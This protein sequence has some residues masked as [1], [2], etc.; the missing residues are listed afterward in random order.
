M[1]VKTAQRHSDTDQPVFFSTLAGEK[2]VEHGGQGTLLVFRITELLD[3]ERGDYSWHGP[4]VGDVLVVDSDENPELNGKVLRGMEVRFAPTWT[5]RGQAKPGDDV[6]RMRDIPE[7]DNE[8]GDDVIARIRLKKGKSPNGFV[9]V[10]EPTG[11]EH[12]AALKAIK[13]AGGDDWPTSGDG[14][15]PSDR[16]KAAGDDEPP[17]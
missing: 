2:F 4:L 17:F 9:I 11:A 7:G 10:D 15:R 3:P 6:K 1:A 12:K 16:A 13:D 14:A 5:L 8:V